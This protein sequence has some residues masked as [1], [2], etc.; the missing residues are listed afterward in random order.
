MALDLNVVRSAFDGLPLASDPAFHRVVAEGKLRHTGVE[1]APDL[2]DEYSARLVCS[3]LRSNAR[4][5]ILIVFPDGLERRT[6]LLFATALIMDG[7]AHIEAGNVGRCVL[8]VSSYAGIRRQLGSVRIKSMMLDSVFAQHYGRGRGD[9]LRVVSLPGGINLPFVLCIHAPADPGG[10]L[11]Q[12]RPKWVAVDCGE[13]HE[14]P[15]LPFVLLEARKMG[16][17]VVGWT[18]KPFSGAVDQ[19]LAAGGGVFRW[20]KVR[21]AAGPRI[22]SLEQLS[23]GAIEAEI[24]PRILTGEH[25]IEISKAFATATEALL[26]AREFQNGR[27]STDAVLLGWKYLR[28]ME[29][30]PVPLEVYEREANSYWGMRRIAELRQNFARFVEAVQPLSPKLHATL[31][32]AADALSRAHERIGSSDSPLWLGLANLCVESNSQ[33]RIVFAS[34]ARREM[35]SLCLLARFNISED[36]LKDVGVRL[37][38]ISQA[39]EPDPGDF[40]K[41]AGNRAGTESGPPLLV[42][43]PSRFAEKH[44]DTLL[45][46]DQLEVLL[47]PHHEPIF[48]RRV[49]HLSSRLGLSS[50]MLGCLLPTLDVDDDVSS[51]GE[52]HA[53]RPGLKLAR[54]R[55]APARALGDELRRKAEVVSLW[56]HPDAS[57]AIA[58]L[59]G[60]V[61]HVEDEE[62]YSP[63]TVLDEAAAEKESQGT[64]DNTWVQEA[65]ELQLEGGLSVLLPSDETVNVILGSQGGAQVEPRYVRSVRIGDEIL[66]IQG[67]RRQSLYELL[68]SRVHRDPVIAQYLA[69]VRRWQ[70]DFVRAFSEAERQGKAS[71]ES[72]LEELQS[73][74]SRLTSPLTIRSWS[75]RLVLAPNDSEDLRRIAEVLS[76]RFVRS[77]Y[78][79]IDTA[80]KRLKGLHINL[81]ARLNRWL[82]SSGAGSVAVGGADE[83]IDA[84][85]GLTVEDFRHSLLRVRILDVREQRGPFYRPHMG[86]LEG[87]RS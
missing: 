60:S 68:V 5:A 37:D 16:V 62:S 32:N 58:G 59:F 20:P 50:R 73:R 28:A 12:H 6:P 24:T 2:V 15:W 45:D 10:L 14:L 33:R 84:E 72:L 65:L 80:G 22:T 25:V 78:K 79:Q 35:F 69:L 27:L 39:E 53:E 66:F 42:G 49:R 21:R 18:T 11:R 77:Y 83:V 13:S 48:E 31:Q 9:D 17:P 63:P 56:K 55:E 82:A 67:Q 85:L 40:D 81:S 23:E 4:D 46:S 64:A 57:E 47:W 86:R 34:R 19:W 26:T 44:L 71:P 29:A 41:K 38:Y 1:G 87:G 36:D 75:R 61:A 76:L 43:M 70:D 7:L 30:V 54:S 8:Y 3:A 74:G 51:R 52:S